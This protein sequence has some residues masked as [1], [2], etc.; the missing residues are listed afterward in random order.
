MR[1]WN[2]LAV[3]LAFI[4]V[5]AGAAISNLVPRAHAQFAAQGLWIPASGVGGTGNA[6]T[7]N[8]PNV[9]QMGDLLGVPIR[10]KPASTN[11]A[12][13]TTIAIIANGGSVLT[14]YNVERSSSGLLVPVAGGDFSSGATA[15]I[16]KVV[17]DGSYFEQSDP[18]TGNDAVGTEK[19]FT[20]TVPAGWLTEDGSCESAATYAALYAYYGSTDLWLTQAGG[21]ACASG[22]FHLPLA[23][24]RIA[25]AANNQGAGTGPLTNCSAG[26]AQNCGAQNQ[27]LSSTNQLPQFTP[28]GTVSGSIGGSQSFGNVQFANGGTRG[29]GGSGE[30]PSTLT[31]NGSSF[32]WSG[33][34]SGAAIGSATPSSFSIVNPNYQVFKAVKY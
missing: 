18:A 19:D 13:G 16:V 27:A 30:A 17:W 5:V 8:I 23:N 12:G 22:A 7:L 21:V 14:A 24:G 15:P 3:A 9:T 11:A 31:V 29:V 4:G 2:I 1:R 32:S 28:S 25:L 34:F 20:N 26:L 33:S 6:V 10:F